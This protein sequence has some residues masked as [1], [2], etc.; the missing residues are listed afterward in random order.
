MAAAVPTVLTRAEAA[1]LRR[2]Q[3]VPNFLGRHVVM[4]TNRPI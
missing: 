4:V 2:R 1:A 3:L